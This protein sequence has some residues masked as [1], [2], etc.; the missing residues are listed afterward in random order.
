M[1]RAIIFIAICTICIVQGDEYHYKWTATVKKDQQH[2]LALVVVSYPQSTLVFLDEFVGGKNYTAGSSFTPK[3][4]VDSAEIKAFY[5][6]NQTCP[7]P[8]SPKT[9]KFDHVKIRYIK[10]KKSYEK[11][12]TNIEMP[13]GCENATSKTLSLKDVKELEKADCF[14]NNKYIENEEEFTEDCDS[15]CHCMDGGFGCVDRCT[16]YQ[17]D[18]KKCQRVKEVSNCCTH[19]QCV[20]DMEKLKCDTT[21]VG[22]DF[23]PPWAVEIMTVDEKHAATPKTVCAGTIIN[24]R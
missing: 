7:P 4:N 23:K 24:S 14:V 21:N 9:L 2:V 10:S 13:L 18:W 15:V 12:L 11:I 8:N 22:P 19:A 3:N 20:D 6:T 16:P 5:A 1:R 17:A